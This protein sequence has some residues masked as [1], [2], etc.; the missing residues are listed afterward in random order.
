MSKSSLDDKIK[1]I[2]TFLENQPKIPPVR[3]DQPKVDLSKSNEFNRDELMTETLAKVYLQQKNKKALYAYKILI[4]KY[5][6]K[7]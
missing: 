3:Q 2:D 4:L 1:L 7:K 6:E 5:P